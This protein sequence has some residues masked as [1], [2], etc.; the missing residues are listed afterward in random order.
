M[1]P[2]YG[3]EAVPIPRTA[4]NS[5]MN[6]YTGM[7][8]SEVSKLINNIGIDYR[9]IGSGTVVQNHIPAAGQRAP[10]NAPVF[11]YLDADTVYDG[12]MVVIPHV[13]GLN[14]ETGE[15]YVREAL[16]IPVSFIDKPDA[17]AGMYAGDPVTT[18]PVYANRE[19]EPAAAVS[20]GKIYKQ[21]P[22][23]GSVVQKGTQIKLKVRVE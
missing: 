12:E 2:Q 7:Q 17:A 21:F 15:D 18:Y 1:L 5:E 4:Q 16:L 20:E 19:N 23:A 3:D 14:M 9:V 8:F 13:E 6:D 10:E 22:E 11:F